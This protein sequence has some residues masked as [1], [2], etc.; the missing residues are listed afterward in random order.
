MGWEENVRRVVPYVP[1]EQPK[2]TDIIKL[3][4]NENPYPPA[5]GV[6]GVLR[7]LEADRLRLYPDP[8]IGE[9]VGAI[10]EFYGVEDS[11]V[12]VG[13]GSDDVLAMIFMTFFNGDKPV[14]FPDITYSFYDVWAE[15]FRIHYEQLPLD[16]EFRIRP[17]DYMR[18]NGG[19][20]FPNPNAPTGEVLPLAEIEKI[21]A[22][23][24]EVIVV[25]DEAYI[26]FGGESALPL[27]NRYENLIVVQTFSKSRSMAG[28]RIGYAI[29]SPKVIRYLNAVKY[30][31]NSYTMDSVTIALGVEAIRDRRYFEE[32]VAKVVATRERA[33]ERL[34]ALGFVCGDSQSNFLF[35]RHPDISGEELFEALKQAGIY[36][37]HFKKPER[38]REYL[39]ISIGTEEQMERLY[40]FLKEYATC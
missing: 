25:A 15:L 16:G 19:V 5:P 24:P 36:V 29:S 11:Q 18:P 20:I 17:G 21:V 1:G 8:A 12:F 39:R 10:A 34:R 33:K 9:L 35:V 37:R 38:I 7:G 14:L 27:V 13:V 30:S 23:N 22:A 3:N 31:F 40:A 2:R 4:T 28:S 6:A 26:D 32:T